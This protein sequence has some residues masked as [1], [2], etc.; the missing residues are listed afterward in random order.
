MMFAL[1]SQPVM[2][3]VVEQPTETTGA[4][5]VLIGA[6]G[7]TGVLILLALMLGG[8][9]GGILIGIKKLRARYDLEPVPESDALK[10]T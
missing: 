9:L 2:V 4:A 6:F 5:D 10:I 3:R 7:L 8:I 1:M